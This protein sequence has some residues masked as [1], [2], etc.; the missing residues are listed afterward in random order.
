MTFKKGLPGNYPKTMGRWSVHMA[1]SYTAM[2]RGPAPAP[3]LAWSAG[4]WRAG[5]RS[6]LLK[7]GGDGM[8]LEGHGGQHKAALRGH[9]PLAPVCLHGDPIVPFAPYP[10][11]ARL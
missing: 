4:P 10:A 1:E 3:T 2:K 7:G 6:P 8:A 9:L 5:E 11:T